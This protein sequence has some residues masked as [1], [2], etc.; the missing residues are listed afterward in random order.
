M[1][2]KI[3][4]LKLPIIGWREWVELPDLGINTLKAKID[5]GARS[6]SLHAFDVKTFQHEGETWVRFKVHPK[7]RSAEG[8]ISTEAKVLEFR[9]VRSSNGHVGKRPVIV[10]NI[11]VLGNTWPIEVTLANRDAMGF[12]MLLGREGIRGRLL[13]DSGAS[14]LGGRGPK[15]KKRRTTTTSRSATSRISR[16]K[17]DSP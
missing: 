17:S 10:T 6:S 8:T 4:P 11:K 14:Y 1:A 7:Q 16:R 13:V 3:Q 12:R 15:T 9:T 2:S 5:T